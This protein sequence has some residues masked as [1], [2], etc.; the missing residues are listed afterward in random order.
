MHIFVYIELLQSGPK[1]EAI[2]V[3]HEPLEPDM[4]VEEPLRESATPTDML[5]SSEMASSHQPLLQVVLEQPVTDSL[6]LEVTPCV[7]QPQFNVS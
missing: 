2:S 7:Q 5:Q 1:E 6:L 3:D 4:A